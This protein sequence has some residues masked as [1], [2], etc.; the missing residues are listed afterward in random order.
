MTIGGQRFGPALSEHL[1]W[2][3]VEFVATLWL[4]TPFPL[5]AVIGWWVEEKASRWKALLIS[6][7]A[8]ICLIYSYFEGYEAAK[9][10]E[11]DRRWTAA[12]LD[13]GFLPFAAAPVVL[14][15]WLIGYV[16]VRTKRKAGGHLVG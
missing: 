3:R 9:V 8:T 4:L 2:A 6:G 10:A 14:L 5:L 1:Y 16:A 12:T 15:A 11:L 7:V 13:I